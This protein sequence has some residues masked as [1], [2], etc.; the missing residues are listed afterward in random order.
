ME[1]FGAEEINQHLKNG[2]QVKE[3]LPNTA[4][5]SEHPEEHTTTSESF[6][7]R[8]YDMVARLEHK[9]ISQLFMTAHGLCENL[10]KFDQ[11]ASPSIGFKEK[12]KLKKA[13]SL[14][15]KVL[16]LD[17][18]SVEAL[19]FKAKC[20]NCLDNNHEGYR[21]LQ[22]AIGIS[23][24]HIIL[25]CEIGATLLQLE[26][27]QKARHAMEEAIT[28]FPEEPRILGNL[29]LAYLFDNKPEQALDVYQELLKVEPEYPLN[30]RLLS[31][32]E[33]ILKGDSTYPK[34]KIDLQ[35]QI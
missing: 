35:N 3:I 22:T 24:P 6:S 8:G 17:P 4:F 30:A 2:W 5:L 23:P 27:Y 34:S 14:Y 29:G 19:L 21:A 10:L 12:Q 15:D 9:E 16:S 11:H 31:Y 13:L 33:R 26:Y 32:T 18:E 25:Y 1:F 28:H 20:Y 7:L